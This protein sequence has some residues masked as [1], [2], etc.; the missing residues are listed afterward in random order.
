MADN[1][2]I[3]DIVIERTASSQ[4]QELCSGLVN[5]YF[6]TNA[7]ANTEH[8]FGWGPLNNLSGAVKLMVGSAGVLFA[9]NGSSQQVEAIGTCGD[10][11]FESLEVEDGNTLMYDHNGLSFSIKFHLV[12][13]AAIEITIVP[14]NDVSISAA[15]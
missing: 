13:G 15:G 4:V 5:T 12:D 10:G 2:I 3:L 6:N 8:T 9:Y 14:G 11:V 1:I 7:S